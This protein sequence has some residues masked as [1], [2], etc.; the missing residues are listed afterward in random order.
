MQETFKLFTGLISDINRN[1]RRIK[2]EIMTEYELKCPHVSTIYY[3]YVQKELTLKELC[4]K[5]NED[6][7]AISRC[8]KS[9]ES[10]GLVNT[11]SG[12]K[13]YKNKLTL[14]EKGK[15]IGENIAKKINVAIEKATEGL[16]QEDKDELYHSLKTICD[17]LTKT[18][19]T[20]WKMSNGQK[21]S[22]YEGVSFNR[23]VGSIN[24]GNI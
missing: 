21:R 22:S 2:T 14:T 10:E 5:C 12:N 1:I 3:L 7:G 18:N 19:F 15:S 16:S 13:K 17:N 23:Y 9:L 6:K 24:L 8:V 20:K 4:E 11:V